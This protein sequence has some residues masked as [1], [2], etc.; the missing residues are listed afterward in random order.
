VAEIKKNSEL[1]I[2]TPQTLFFEN[3]KIEKIGLGLLEEKDIKS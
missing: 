3:Q 2:R 1:N